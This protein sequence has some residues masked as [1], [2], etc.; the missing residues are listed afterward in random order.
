M[1]RCITLSL[2]L[3]FALAFM[4]SCSGES[5]NI[6]TPTNGRDVVSAEATGGTLCFG[7][8]QI[9]IDP[10]TGTGDVVQLRSADK[11]INVL[12]F[13]EPPP[14]SL[15]DLDW[16]NLVI[17]DA[18]SII[19]VGVILTHPIAGDD[20]FTGFDVRGVC[21]G[22]K[23]ANGD[24]A[25]IIP[26]PEYF[27][28]VPF[29]WMDGLLG[30]PDSFGNYEGVAGYKYFCDGLGADE[31]LAEF[32]S[33]TGNLDDRGKYGAGNTNQR[34]YILDWNGV[35][36]D[37]FVFNYAI[38]ANYDWPTGDPPI[39]VDSFSISSANS[40]EA[41]ACSVTELANSLYFAG[42]SGGGEISLLIETWDWQGD[43]SNVTV[44]S[45]ESGIIAQA[46]YDAALG[47]MGTPYSYGYEFYALPGSPLSV[48]DL[49]ILITVTDTMTFGESWFLDLLD[50]GH[51][52]YDEKVYNCFIHTTEV[53][54]CP[55][56]EITS[57]D[58]VCGKIDA[59]VDDMAIYGT[60]MDGASLGAR[61]VLSGETDIIGTDVTFVDATEVTAD[62]DLT[63]ATA[64]DWDVVVTNGCGTDGI[65]A[66]GFGVLQ[67]AYFTSF[68]ASE[69]EDTNWSRNT[70]YWMC[71]WFD[72]GTINSNIS[73]CVHYGSSG[74]N[75]YAWRTAGIEIP[76][77]WTGSLTLA[78]SHVWTAQES[79]WER[80]RIQY[81]TNGSSWYGLN[82]YD[83]PYNY[84]GYW[85]GSFSYRT[86]H[87]T[88]TSYV[89]PGGT[90]WI[91]YHLYVLDSIANAAA[92][93][94][95]YEMSIS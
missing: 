55:P 21:F 61:L 88:L 84:A 85:S 77:C 12:G 30:A 74:H 43:I 23:V 54:E 24:G 46:G 35:T 92:G 48:G 29:G 2:I 4:I 34:D 57:I 53:I 11:I 10:A 45:M 52:M 28:G 94:S 50:P 67:Y 90:I 44:E 56:A 64:G 38:Y 89:S 37:F 95:I 3:I 22:P 26:G 58:P 39:T 6:V 68:D 66:A 19:E 33:D 62:F 47:T 93:W 70:P 51:A 1:S 27:T 49:D 31:D 87:A 18:E 36:Q 40:A 20:V 32:M 79:Y 7:L 71:H 15:M 65:L 81:S 76:D 8:W 60:F 78:V 59:I 14:L 73:S 13:M 83:H 41:F 91:R 17:N 82:F 75:S 86:D 25:T 69:N 9:S 80:V 72:N 63:G 16:P 42:T 5:E